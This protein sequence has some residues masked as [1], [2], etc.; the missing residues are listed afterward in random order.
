[1]RL[2]DD[3]LRL[4]IHKEARPIDVLCVGNAL[5]DRLAEGDESVVASAGLE[6]GAMTLVDAER[7]ALIEAARP[8][9]R[10]VAGGS[11]ANTAA[12]IAS[13]GRRPAFVGTV[14]DDEAGRR[15]VADLEAIGVQAFVHIADHLPTGLCHVLVSPGGERSMATSLGAAGA[16]DE[17]AVLGAGI[18][19]ASIVY[20]EGYLLDAPAAGPALE[21]VVELARQAGTLV[22]LSLSDPFVVERHRAKINELLSSGL[23]DIV[24]GNEDEA[25]G[26]TGAPT[27][28]EAAGRL[29]KKDRLALVTRGAAGSMAL[30]GDARLDQPAHR[31]GAVRDT[32]GAGDL[33]AAGVLGGLTSG[34]DVA[35][36][37]R[38]GSLAAAEVISHFGARPEASLAELARAEIG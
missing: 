11:A 24:F 37:L 19:S 14:G 38:L 9:W 15:Y 20:L 4:T 32:T 25:R 5:V 16:L 30:A 12:G 2:L 34:H 10:E 36:S 35:T 33:F 27:T 31:V 21:R 23:V 26:L 3:A 6:L 22:A 28:E 17:A 29:D 18:E 7:A 1:M 13:L 8:D